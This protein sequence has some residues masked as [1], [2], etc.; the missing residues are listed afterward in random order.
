MSSHKFKAWSLSSQL[1]APPVGIALLFTALIAGFLLY[2][3]ASMDSASRD[4]E[5]ALV[6]NGF[7][8]RVTE[9]EALVTPNADWDDAV[10]NLAVAYSPD[11]ARDNLGIYFTQTSHFQLAFLVDGAG[12]VIYGRNAGDHD[13]ANPASFSALAQASGRII[14][15]VRDGEAARGP[16]S[17]SAKGDMISR[18]IQASTVTFAGGQPMVMTATLVQPDFG[19]ALPAGPRAPIIITGRGLTGDFLDTFSNRYLLADARVVADAAPLPPGLAHAALRVGD[20]AAVAQMQW[21][22]QTP[23]KI[24]LHR[25][26]APLVGL[27][28]MVFMAIVVIANGLRRRVL[29]PLGDATRALIDLSQDRPVAMPKGME[30]TGEIGDLCRAF[31]RLHA[32]AEEAKELRSKARIDRE[33]RDAISQ[34]DQAARM[35]IADQQQRVVSSLARGLER[36]SQGQLGYRISEPFAAEYEKL[37]T[38]FNA[39]LEELSRTILVI[40]DSARGIAAG[41][42]NVRQDADDLSNRTGRQAASLEESSRALGDITGALRKTADGVTL[43]RDVVAAA[44]ADAQEGGVVVGRAVEAMAQIEYSS[45]RIGEIIGVI[46]EIAFQTNLLAL[47]A[48][49]EAAR[50]GDSG[51][52]FAVV[53]SEVRALAQRSADAAKEIKTLV[54]E[55]GAHVSAGVAMVGRSGAAL[56][57]IVARVAE[58]NDVVDEIAT[59]AQA[60]ASAVAGVNRA[61]GELDQLA[62]QNSTMV[63]QSTQTTH[64]LAGEATQ[65]NTLVGRFAVDPVRKAE[66]RGARALQDTLT[67]RLGH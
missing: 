45:G 8:A 40:A 13:D 35:S 11:W 50:A 43:A 27:L 39:T 62:R 54:S 23:G 47:N 17:P 63:R 19:K 51:R 38:V 33:L 57:R 16:L 6:R 56:E 12:Q 34:E 1:L 14:A 55:S 36:L 5:E 28:A 61:V 30:R 3:P 41:V 44:R 53:A 32:S 31:A 42:D 65:L 49:V 15:A 46:D 52:G 4:R 37:R 60:Q 48:G 7:A 24:L 59:S 18:P 66:G 2:W 21:R 25:V 67:Q 29:V 9:L 64:A 26:A 20:E 10:Q 58:I 22:P